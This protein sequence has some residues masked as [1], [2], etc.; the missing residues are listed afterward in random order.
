VMLQSNE[1]GYS[2]RMHI[3]VNGSLYRAY[4]YIGLYSNNKRHGYGISILTNGDQYLGE[5]ING[6][7]NGIVVCKFKSGHNRL[8][9]YENGRRVRW[10]DGT[11]AD[12]DALNKF[13]IDLT[14]IKI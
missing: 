10:I 12:M 13:N 5:F 6:M 7:L 1:I 11:S 2:S 8:C 14:G 9:L 4:R 3:G